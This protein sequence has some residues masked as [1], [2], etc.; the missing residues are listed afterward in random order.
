MTEFDL[1]RPW[2]V[3]RGVALRPERFGALAY[4]F[5]TR[6]LSFLKSRRLF[7]VVRTL[8]D[9]PSGRAACEAAGVLGPELTQVS[10]ALSTLADTGMII[11]RSAA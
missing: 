10:A 8:A 1:D 3:G 4:S 11:E 6:R 5:D 2:Q 9:H 7:E